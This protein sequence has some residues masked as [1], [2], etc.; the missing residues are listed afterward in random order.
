MTSFLIK[1]ETQ[2]FCLRFASMNSAE[3]ISLLKSTYKFIHHLVRRNSR[4]TATKDNLIK[5]AEDLH[6]VLNSALGKERSWESLIR[7]YMDNDSETISVPFQY[8][9]SLVRHREVVLHQGIAYVPCT[10]LHQ[11]LASLFEQIIADGLKRARSILRMVCQDERM[12]DLFKELRHLYYAGCRIGSTPQ[13]DLD[14]I[15]CNAVDYLEQSF[16]PCMQNLHTAL[17]QKH[18]LRHFSRVR[19]FIL[20]THMQISNKTLLED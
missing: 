20:T 18:R 17:R 11:I 3:L 14:P 19:H 2:L 15:G 6:L 12:V 4:K 8:A 5:S 7:K 16:P 13:W 1:S 9:L 10:K